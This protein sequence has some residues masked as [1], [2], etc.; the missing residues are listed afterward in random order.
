[1]GGLVTYIWTL[2]F[3]PETGEKWHDTLTLPV[4]F[5]LSKQ[6]LLYFDTKNFSFPQPVHFRYLVK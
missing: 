3:G 1:M 6:I 4:L 5:I 2:S